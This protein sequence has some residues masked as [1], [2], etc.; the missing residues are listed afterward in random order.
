MVGLRGQVILCW[1]VLVCVFVCAHM[2]KIIPSISD[3][4]KVGGINGS[5]SIMFQLFIYDSEGRTEIFND[6]NV[7]H[8]LSLFLEFLIWIE[9]VKK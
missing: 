2:D 8:L 5:S 3:L 6:L 7:I 4:F 1:C 9:P